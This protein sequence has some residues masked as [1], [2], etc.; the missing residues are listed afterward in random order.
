MDTIMRCVEISQ[1]DKLWLLLYVAVNVA[2]K[3][4][5]DFSL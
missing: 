5:A 1:D 3:Q 2:E 4:T